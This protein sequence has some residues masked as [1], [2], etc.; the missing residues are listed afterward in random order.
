MT[1][2]YDFNQLYG[3]KYLKAD[4]LPEE[5]VQVMKITAYSVDEVGKTKEVKCVL[6]FAE[7]D[8]QLILNKTNANTLAE[9]YGKDWAGWVGK[10][11]ALY[12]TPVDFQGKTTM[13]VRIKPRVPK[14]APPEQPPK[15][16]EQEIISEVGFDNPP[17]DDY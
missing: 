13:A 8:K 3:G 10:R 16:T 17:E 9:L 6:S 7:T 5:G 12:Q 15:R 2:E 4:D 14:P 11:I 1:I